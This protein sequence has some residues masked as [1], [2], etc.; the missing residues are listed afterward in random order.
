MEALVLTWGKARCC[1]WVS[2]EVW[3]E[4]PSLEVVAAHTLRLLTAKSKLSASSIEFLCKELLGALS[5]DLWMPW[6]RL[7]MVSDA[8]ACYSVSCSR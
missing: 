1:S 5:L 3:P 7:K 8:L 2:L 6:R 4:A